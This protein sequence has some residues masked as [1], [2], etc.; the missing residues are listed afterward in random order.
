MS[1]ELSGAREVVEMD[2]LLESLDLGS[3]DDSGKV[4]SILIWILIP[5]LL[6]T[7]ALTFVSLNG[8]SDQTSKLAHDIESKS[9][10]IVGDNDKVGSFSTNKV[11]TSIIDQTAKERQLS[12]SKDVNKE[13]DANDIAQDVKNNSKSEKLKLEETNNRLTTQN[14]SNST[15][16][17]SHSRTE[18]KPNPTIQTVNDGFF[19]NLSDNSDSKT[20]KT[21]LDKSQNSLDEISYYKPISENSAIRN[22][23][24][25]PSGLAKSISQVTKLEEV[26]QELDGIFSRMKINCPSFNQAFWRLALVP[27]VGVFEPYKT[28]EQK[29]GEGSLAFD[30][31]NRY[32]QSLE[33]I[34][35][36]L[37]GMVVRD[38]LPVYLKAGVSYSRIAE[39][40][41]YNY[42]DTSYVTELG[43]VSSTVSANGDTITHIY[44]DV[45]SEV[46]SN[47]T[48]R[49]HNYIHLFD[50]PISVGYNTYVLG[51]DVGLEAGV[52]VNLM[53]R[54]TG[55]LLT[56]NNEFINL[57]LNRYFKP[58][59]GLSYFGGLMIGR[60]FGRFGDFYLAPRFTY[61]PSDFS[62]NVNSVSQK[63]VT[64]GLNAGFV[65]KIK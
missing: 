29:T 4:G 37:Y 6:F 12:E 3:Q 20:I 52:K 24:E 22:A 60:N 23:I 31:R 45:I 8:N 10:L 7:S 57:S 39:Q 65:Y 54:A 9:K 49:Q 47:R 36:G 26:D 11:N 50:M 34:N 15:R 62:S 38:K 13:I 44:G 14:T 63:Y 5:F 43:I 56:D 59:I 27:E 19:S 28:L 17:F 41:N 1:Q 16:L 35:L 61:Y 21:T 25:E 33:G 58:K 32:E 53:T 64:I 51:F 30:Q 55:A 46:I 18:K 40:L 48:G 42:S 2:A